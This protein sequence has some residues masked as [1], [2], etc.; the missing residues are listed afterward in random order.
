MDAYL[1]A[2]IIGAP[3]LRN[4]HRKRCLK[5]SL[6]LDLDENIKPFNPSLAIHG[7]TKFGIARVDSFRPHLDQNYIFDKNSKGSRN[8]L[9]ELDNNFNAINPSWLSFQSIPNELKDSWLSYE[10]LRLFSWRQG[11]WAIGALHVQKKYEGE[12]DLSKRICRQALVKIEGNEM[13]LHS[14]FTSP[15]KLKT[16]KNWVPLVI[17]D[18]LYFFYSIDPLALYKFD[19]SKLT[20]NGSLPRSHDSIRLRGSSQLV[21][22]KDDLYL[23]LAH[24][25]RI[26]TH[27]THYLHEFVIFDSSSMQLIETSEPFFLHKRGIEFATGLMRHENSILISYGVSDAACFIN[28][29]SDEDLKDWLVN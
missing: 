24:W 5:I 1:A 18:D 14:I 19:G 16:E 26:K 25:Q 2:L 23:G 7:N 4:R 6:G 9:Y 20:L 27:K 12:L 13:I 10:D 22:W 21:H 11:L 17:G 8:I 3:I 29:I 28:Q 15:L